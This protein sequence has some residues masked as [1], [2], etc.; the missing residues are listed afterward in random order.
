MPLKILHV[1]SV[2]LSVANVLD[3][4]EKGF[5]K[6]YYG[7]QKYQCGRGEPETELCMDQKCVIE[8]D[9]KESGQRCEVTTDQNEY[10]RI[11]L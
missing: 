4:S 9:S 6:V 1:L 5:L 10:D 7:G 3:L 2:C 8:S 11:P